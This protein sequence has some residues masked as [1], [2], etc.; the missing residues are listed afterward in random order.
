[1]KKKI[2]IISLSL[3]L[4]LILGVLGYGI[5]VN[6]VDASHHEKFVD[7]D[8][9]KDDKRFYEGGDVNALRKHI[10]LIADNG[11][12]RI[13]EATD[14]KL[15][16]RLVAGECSITLSYYDIAF[17]LVLNVLPRD[18]CAH[19]LSY[20]KEVTA[21]SCKEVGSVEY[22]R[23]MLCNK[24]FSD[25]DCTVEILNTVAEPAHHFEDRQ[26]KICGEYDANEGFSYAFNEEGQY[27]SVTGLI[28]QWEDEKGYLIFPKTHRGY[29]VKE[30][31]KTPI[32]TGY[33][34]KRVLIQSN[35][36]KIDYKI[37]RNVK[38]VTVLGN[39][40]TDIGDNIFGDS[41]ITSAYIPASLATHVANES[42]EEINVH[43]GDAIPNGAFS[44]CKKL[45]CVMLSDSITHIG[46]DA[47]LGC[48]SLSSE[49]GIFYIGDWIVGCKN[50]AS[51]LE[52]GVSLSRCAVGALCNTGA[53]EFKVAEKNQ[54]FATV[55]GVLYSKDL[56]TLIAYPTMKND[57]DFEIPEGVEN[58]GD[59]AFYNVKSLKN[60]TIPASVRSI[61]YAALSSNAFESIKV[62]EENKIFTVLDDVLYTDE[63]SSII[64]Y[65]GAS[66]RTSLD[67][68]ATVTEIKAHAFENS[69]KLEEIHISMGLESIGKSAFLGCKKLT[70][71]HLTSIDYWFSVKLEDGYS[72][73]I[74]AAPE[75]GIYIYG[76]VVS[77]LD[78]PSTTT[79]IGDY[80]FYGNKKLETVNFPDSL[81]TIGYSSFRSSGLKDKL[82]IPG[83]IQT[84]NPYAFYETKIKSVVIV[85]E[86]TIDVYNVHGEEV[87]TL[88]SGT[89]Y[90]N[91]EMY[92]L[93]KRFTEE[94]ASYFFIR[95]TRQ[96]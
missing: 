41:P 67:L 55:D 22:Y 3:V 66:A 95:H 33:S 35:I 64:A 14:Y 96:E 26:C 10:R 83:G 32:Y 92:S 15:K 91:Y 63:Y 78:V 65:A 46:K 44:G 50:D 52:I 2:L 60:I 71:L 17:N 23:C 38:D 90:S 93:G 51:A 13:F 56:K 8:F 37:F 20:H 43:S 57:A 79:E 75:S 74:A 86:P 7:L 49:G 36:E 53:T 48:T 27:Y 61:G 54:Y 69:A 76:E 11:A 6:Y 85:G 70:K 31:L 21:A 89:L 1:M 29:P 82:T 47:F 34:S 16:G 45:R 42:L 30:I 81:E 84:I 80:L 62:N 88:S 68:P 72:N 87:H 77:T 40:L 28:W 12:G 19:E 5:Y 73:P 59:Y 39:N 94:W 25:K 18:A 58:I 4:A 24:N 9:Y